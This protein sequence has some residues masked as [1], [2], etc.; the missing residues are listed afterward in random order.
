M[1]PDP[2]EADEPPDR[3]TDKKRGQSLEATV[4][5][6]DALAATW[7]E[8]PNGSGLYASPPCFMHELDLG[9]PGPAAEFATQLPPT[10]PKAASAKAGDEGAGG[11]AA[12]SR[13]PAG[14]H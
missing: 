3:G 11:V 10:H 7:D 1:T 8:D 4:P 9:L 2:P 14:R 13:R 6:C 12:E 5:A